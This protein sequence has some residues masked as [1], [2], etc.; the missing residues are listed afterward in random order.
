MGRDLEERRK[1]LNLLNILG[2]SALAL[3]TP[4]D[5]AALTALEF[6]DE[7]GGQ[8]LREIAYSQRVRA[9]ELRGQ[10]AA[11]SAEYAARY[12]SGA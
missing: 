10:L 1:M 6:A 9:L 3:E 2:N 8:A 5:D 11:L 4:T 12:Y 7:I